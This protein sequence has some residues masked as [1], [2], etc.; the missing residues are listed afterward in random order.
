MVSSCESAIQSSRFSSKTTHIIRKLRNESS[1]LLLRGGELLVTVRT[2][3]DE[4]VLARV[5]D[6]AAVDEL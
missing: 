3:D 1:S 6:D 5:L 2:V 4:L